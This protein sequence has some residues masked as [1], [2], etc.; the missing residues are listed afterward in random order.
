[1]FD[2]QVCHGSFWTMHGQGFSC[3]REVF[4]SLSRLRNTPDWVVVARRMASTMR[5]PAREFPRGEPY[6]TYADSIEYDGGFSEALL[7]LVDSGV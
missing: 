2:V 3:L 5:A 4:D 6:L 1:M 7:W